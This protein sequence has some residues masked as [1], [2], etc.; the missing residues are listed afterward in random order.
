MEVSRRRIITYINEKRL[1]N[2]NFS[3]GVENEKARKI[4][5]DDICASQASSQPP[6]DK[7]SD[8]SQN[9]LETLSEE[10]YMLGCATRSKPSP[11]HPS[12]N[13]RIP[14]S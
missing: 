8:C 10:F 4:D 9:G 6:N 14:H 11:L 3:V 12:G 7:V 5:P 13:R 1:F 2:K